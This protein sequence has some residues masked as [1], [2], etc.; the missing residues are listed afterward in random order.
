MSLLEA[1][2][3]KVPL[4]FGMVGRPRNVFAG[5][6]LGTLVGRCQCGLTMGA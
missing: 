4:V 5:V 2:I 3:I 6:A 1:A